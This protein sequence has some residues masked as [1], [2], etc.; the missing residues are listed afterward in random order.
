MALN[1]PARIC[2]CRFRIKHG[3]LC[4]CEKQRKE[5]HDARRASAAA[6]GYDAAWRKLRAEHL[7]RQPNCVVC[8]RPG[9]VVDHIK[10]VRT[11]PEL[12]LDPRNLQT[13]CVSCH[14]SVAQRQ[15]R[16]KAGKR[17]FRSLQLGGDRKPSGTS[18]RP[19]RGPSRENFPNPAAKS[20]VSI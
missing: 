11:Y 19:A 16:G 4:P 15:E 2:A 1:K 5:A 7:R 17:A 12:R 8:G 13:M 9:K 3:E 6:R 18:P 14:S 20:E 10:P